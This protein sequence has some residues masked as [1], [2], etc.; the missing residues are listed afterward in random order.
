MALREFIP[1]AALETLQKRKYVIVVHLCINIPST[2]ASAVNYTKLFSTE[3][4]DS[5]QIQ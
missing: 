1:T 5:G 4:D 3:S 2:I